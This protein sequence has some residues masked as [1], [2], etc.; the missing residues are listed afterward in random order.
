MAADLETSCF[1][2]FARIGSCGGM[3]GVL[4][5]SDCV[6]E[7]RSKSVWRQGGF[8]AP[9]PAF[10][11]LP[12]SSTTSQQSRNAQL[13]RRLD[14]HDSCYRTT[15]FTSFWQLNVLVNLNDY[16][17]LDPTPNAQLASSLVHVS[18]TI[19]VPRSS[20]RNTRK[21]IHPNQPFFLS[22]YSPQ[23]STR[24]RFLPP[25]PPASQQPNLP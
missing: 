11:L 24:P 8:N 22:I 19:Q 7:T 14:L 10:S 17:P 12:S 5:E 21:D 1:S 4:R 25:K 6:L 3:A 13:F 2:V 23:L 9:P 18:P 16:L 20:A 15:S